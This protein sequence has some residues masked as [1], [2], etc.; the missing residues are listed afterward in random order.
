[1]LERL[2]ATAYAV[3]DDASKRRYERVISNMLPYRAKKAKGNADAQ[4]YNEAYS[5]PFVPGEF[6]AVRDDRT[7]LALSMSLRFRTFLPKFSACTTMALLT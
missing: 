6:I 7:Q 2:S 3:T 5:V 1:M 4:R